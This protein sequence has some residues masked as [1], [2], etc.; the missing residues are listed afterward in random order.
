MFIS[1]GFIQ[2]GF[3]T[4]AYGK[5]Y[6]Y[7]YHML[8]QT[9]LPC[10]EFANTDALLIVQDP[11]LVIVPFDLFAN[12][13]GVPAAPN[14]KYIMLL[15]EP[16]KNIEEWIQKRG[17]LFVQDNFVGFINLARNLDPYF[18]QTFPGKPLFSFNQ[19]FVEYEDIK[20]ESHIAYDVVM[21]GHAYGPDRPEIV[22]QLRQLGLIVYDQM[23]SGETLD[24]VYRRSAV[25]A[26]FPY[27]KEYTAWHGQR[28]LWAV[29]KG[30]CC[31]GVK[32]ED[33]EQEELYKGLYV[34]CERNTLV[35]TVQRIV[36]QQEW[37]QRGQEA[38]QKYKRDFDGLKMFDWNLVHYF[39]LKLGL[40]EPMRAL[41]MF[42]VHMHE[43]A[44][45]EATQVM[46]SGF[47]TQGPK[48]EQFEDELAT[49][50]G[51]S[52]RRLTTVNS[53]TTGLTLAL[54]LIPG[55][56]K[57]KDYVLTS[58]LTCTATNWAVL[59]NDYKLQWVDTEK[60]SP[61]MSLDDLESK[62][63]AHAKIILFVHWGGI[64]VDL[65][66][67]SFILDRH[68]QKHQFRPFVVEDCAH[69][70]GSDFEQKKIGTHGNI[71]VFSMQAIKHLTTGD[72]GFVIWPTNE[73]AQRARLLRWF[74]IDRN[75]P[76]TGSDFRNRESTD[77]KEFGYKWHM[78]DLNAA[79]GIGNLRNI[80]PVLDK[81][82]KHYQS[83]RD[84]IYKLDPSQRVF[85]LVAEPQNAKICGWIF[86]L[87]LPNS[88]VRKRFLQHMTQHTI[89]STQVHF[90]NDIHSCTFANLQAKSSL[91][92]LN[93]LADRYVCIPCGWWLSQA[94]LDYLVHVLKSFIGINYT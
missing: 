66:R 32:S 49:F 28:T 50:F 7:L 85:Q 53:A 11:T 21:P 74:G 18:Q 22:S 45:Q 84:Q 68:E 24:E 57:T 65:A 81:H 38:Y 33:Y 2:F 58:P 48:V 12:H 35:P 3:T 86:T 26:Y 15:F 61:N 27:A 5:L 73:M 83:L 31:V 46:R 36:R 62:L 60:N 67:L 19:G 41:K 4:M 82:T 90:R 1:I 39:R 17:N 40:P 13:G 71:C 63:T 59:A 69:A 16:L 34:P 92:A 30:L 89:E 79:I 93:E 55:F 29:N 91:P 87:L 37:K 10:T 43:D 14:V 80:Q 9:Q 54:K 51:V 76:A 64:P 88:T 23:V 6:R 47:L 25:C 42:K 52:I 56:D 77:I 20:H 70:F 94:D 72:G 78:N 8:K 44:I 75:A